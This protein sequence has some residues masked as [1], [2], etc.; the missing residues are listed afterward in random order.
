M[1]ITEGNG[2]EELVKINPTNPCKEAA[3]SSFQVEGLKCPFGQNNGPRRRLGL[4]RTL[5]EVCHP[6]NVSRFPVRGSLGT[7]LS[8]ERG[9]SGLR[10]TLMVKNN[11]AV[12][13]TSSHDNHAPTTHLH[14][15]PRQWSQ[16][17]YGLQAEPSGLTL[18]G[19]WANGLQGW[20]ADQR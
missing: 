20:E 8:L 17:V 11:L 16:S 15:Q 5:G 14:S 12:E 9:I 13:L 18:G 10:S 6:Q 7:A 19:P 3:G 1:G 4:A 2:R